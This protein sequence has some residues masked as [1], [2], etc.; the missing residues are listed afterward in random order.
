MLW[1][2]FPWERNLTPSAQQTGR[3]L[4][5]VW[6]DAENL[7]PIR[8]NSWTIQPLASPYTNYIN[9]DM[10]QKF[11]EKKLEGRDHLEDIGTDGI[12]ILNFILQIQDVRL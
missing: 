1:L 11:G 7:V 6:T 3:T 4:G 2:L 8:F 5:A 12:I 9:R 10:L